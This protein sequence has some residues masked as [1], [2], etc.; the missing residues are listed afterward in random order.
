VQ[1]NDGFLLGAGTSLAWGVTDVLVTR[2]TRRIGF[3]RALL[4]IHGLSLIPL[5]AVIFFV[6]QAV[7]AGISFTQYA[8][9]AALGP[10]AILAYIGFYRALELG[11]IAIVSPIVSSYGALVVLCALVLLGESLGWLQAAGCLMVFCCVALASVDPTAGTKAEATGTRL[12]IKLSVLSAGAFGAYLFLLAR[13]SADLGWLLPILLNRA[14]SVALLFA[15]MIARPPPTVGKLGPLGVLGC[16]ATGLLDAIGYVLFNRGGEI[17]EIAL[18]GAAAS[19]YP[20]IP[21]AVGLFA[22]HERVAWHQRVGIAGVV[23]GM[24]IL[25]LG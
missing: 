1:V 23:A 13:L 10:L 8:V 15:W 20:L 3:F 12:G 11:P 21:I 9:A 6:P 14:T 24:V 16:A 25:S 22:L 7:P 19:A 17:G 5:V 4:V 18:T 2:Y